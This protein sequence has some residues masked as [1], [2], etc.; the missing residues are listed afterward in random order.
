MVK[1]IEPAKNTAPSAPGPTSCTNPGN[2]ATTKHTDPTAK[3][4]AIHRSQAARV[5][6]RGANASA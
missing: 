2:G 3:P 4:M 6:C 5:A 1:K